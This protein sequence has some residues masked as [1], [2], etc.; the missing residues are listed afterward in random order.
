VAITCV[1][2][3]ILAACG[4]ASYDPPNEVAQHYVAA[5]AEGDDAGACALIVPRARDRIL[6]ATHSH[7]SCPALL[8]KCVPYHVNS[9]NTDQ[10]QLLYVNVELHTRGNVALADLTGLPVARAIRSV[11]LQ[12]EGMQWRLISPGRVVSLCVHRLQRERGHGT[13]KRHTHG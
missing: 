7:I 9:A 4:N 6:A 10:S 8:R 1:L 5:I 3:S 12:R 11:M 2:A 13:G